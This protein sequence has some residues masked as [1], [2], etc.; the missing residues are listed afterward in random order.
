[1]N[2]SARL[3]RSRSCGTTP[4]GWDEAR[5]GSEVLREQRGEEEE[6][7]DDDP[8]PSY[9]DL[10]REEEERRRRTEGG[11]A[12]EVVVRQEEGA[13]ADRGEHFRRRCQSLGVRMREVGEY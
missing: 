8:P 3:R 11:E 2:H 6:E 4:T 13:A 12:V 10:E 7:E 1:M 5:R 9:S